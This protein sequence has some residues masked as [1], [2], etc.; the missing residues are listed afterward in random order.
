M[1]NINLISYYFHVIY[2]RFRDEE[3][4]KNINFLLL[5]RLRKR[6]EDTEFLQIEISF[7][8]NLKKILILNEN[9]IFKLKTWSP[10]NIEKSNLHIKS[11]PAPQ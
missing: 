10:T 7:L 8:K 9:S 3:Y 11:F 4:R 1:E 2:N 6:G 5:A